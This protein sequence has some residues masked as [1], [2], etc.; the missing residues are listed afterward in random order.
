MTRGSK[1]GPHPIDVEVG[2][3]VCE[4]RLLRGYNQSQLG[5]AL[6][7]TFQQIQKYEKGANRI[8]A[9]KLW[10]IADF[11]GVDVGYFFPTKEQI[12]TNAEHPGP[13]MDKRAHDMLAAFDILDTGCKRSLI[14]VARAMAGAA[15][16]REGAAAAGVELKAAA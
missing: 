11:F 16:M 3:R 6:K 8:S 9:S 13:I 15:A 7:I 5:K 4:L 2:R 1:E 12:A 10:Q 14:D